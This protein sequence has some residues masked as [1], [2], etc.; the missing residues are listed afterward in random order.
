MPRKSS[1]FLSILSGR[2][3]GVILSVD[4]DQ[5]YSALMN[6][7][8]EQALPV[9]LAERS[10]FPRGRLLACQHDLGHLWGRITTFFGR[11]LVRE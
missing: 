3:V 10:L 11:R 6:T 1:F 2:P 4:V 7:A 8:I 5:A 9:A